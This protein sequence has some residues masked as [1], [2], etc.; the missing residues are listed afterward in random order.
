MNRRELM[1]VLGFGAAALAVTEGGAGAAET[2]LDERGRQHIEMLGRCA[3]ACNEAAHHCLTQLSQGHGEREHHAKA[4]E[5]A[6]DCQEFC[7]LTAQLMARS[8]PLA[9]YIHEGC[10]EACRCC[11]EEC[12]KASGPSPVMQDCARQCRECERICRA[13]ARESKS[14]RP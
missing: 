12:E 7:V 13:M 14:S 8:S 4:H 5:L 9:K 11:A 1:S 2:E 6:N 10:A 3:R